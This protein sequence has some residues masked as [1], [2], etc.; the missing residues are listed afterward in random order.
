MSATVLRDRLTPTRS[1]RLRAVLALTVHSPVPGRDDWPDFWPV[2][3]QREGEGQE[4]DHRSVM[5][6]GGYARG[7]APERVPTYF[8]GFLVRL[9]HATDREPHPEF[10]RRAEV[11]HQLEQYAVE[12]RKRREAAKRPAV[13]VPPRKASPMSG[14]VHGHG[15]RP[16]RPAS[17]DAPGWWRQEASQAIVH[18]L[19]KRESSGERVPLAAGST[20]KI[21]PNAEALQEARAFCDSHGLNANFEPKSDRRRGPGERRPD[22]CELAACNLAA[23]LGTS[24]SVL[25]SPSVQG[26]NLADP[27]TSVRHEVA[28]T[29]SQQGFS[30]ADIAQ[31]FARP[32]STIR[33]WMRGRKRFRVQWSDGWNA[34]PSWATAEAELKAAVL[35]LDIG[36]IAHRPR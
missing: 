15:R 26:R 23:E 16:T 3:H 7:P 11:Q 36:D 4:V 30:T 6:R 9:A 14:V 13:V 21:R 18:G 27:M 29:L 32:E 24:L 34:P 5:P 8:A 17:P 12:R 28:G 10:T 1:A 35:A 2:T 31:V 25:Q 19:G 20:Y 22:E 33:R